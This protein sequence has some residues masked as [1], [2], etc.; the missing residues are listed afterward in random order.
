MKLRARWSSVVETT[1]FRYD[2]PGLLRRSVKF[3]GQVVYA[4]SPRCTISSEAEAE[5]AADFHP[6]TLSVCSPITAI[7]VQRP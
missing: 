6:Y 2:D 7:A 4:V 3:A 5:T 1:N